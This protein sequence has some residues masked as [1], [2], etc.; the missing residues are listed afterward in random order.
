MLI[1]TIGIT[2]AAFILPDLFRTVQLVTNLREAARNCVDTAG[3][4]ET[5]IRVGNGPS[6]KTA[7][8]Y[9]MDTPGPK[10]AILFIPGL[11]P[12]GILNPRFVAVSRAIARSGYV[13]I[14][15]RLTGF[16]QFKL[17]PAAVGEIGF[18]Y[19][20]LREHSWF[21]LRK[22]G[23]VGVSVGGT[24]ALLA[25]ARQPEC[26]DLDFIVSIGAYK[27]LWRCQ[28]HWFS[29]THGID[30][31]GSYPVQYYGKWILM[32]SALDE[33]EKPGDHARLEQALRDLVVGA[34]T[35]VD[36]CTL[37]PAESIWFNL[38]LG[39]P[40]ENAALLACIT[41][42]LR[43]RF[44]ALSP[45]DQELSTITCP[46]FLVHG[47]YDELIPADETRE[48]ENLLTSTDPITLLTPV[49]SHT[50]PLFD[51]MSFW[52]KWIA[53]AQGSFFLYRFVKA[54]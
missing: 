22:A 12:N 30:S 3:I 16:E 13:V 35:S 24:L 19:G 5:E 27:D 46:V 53:L 37:S 20:Y 17:E 18:W 39:E 29:A 2:F 33:M 4:I 15:P 50:H 44:Q 6:A 26:R 43:K 23:I 41:D 11:T 36:A 54:S 9:Q 34:K 28:Q 1:G 38:A 7:R 49:I 10:S 31:H 21:Q 42:Q 45:G 32:L 51:R 48:L 8:V 52:N 40:E 47:A 14:T 25:A